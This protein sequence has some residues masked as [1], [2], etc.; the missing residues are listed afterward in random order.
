MAGANT[1]R[2]TAIETQAIIAGTSSLDVTRVTAIETQA[3]IAGTSALD[4]VRVSSVEVQ[5]VGSMFNK[6]CVVTVSC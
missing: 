3:I 2:S 5:T 1:V 6:T 4:A